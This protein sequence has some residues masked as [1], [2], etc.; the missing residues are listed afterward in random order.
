MRFL[1]ILTCLALLVGC[2]GGGADNDQVAPTPSSEDLGLLG[3]PNYRWIGLEATTN[4]LHTIYGTAQADVEG[5]LVFRGITNDGQAVTPREAATAYTLGP[6]ASL[7]VQ[8][9]TSRPAGRGGFGPDG[10]Y[11]IFAGVDPS[12]GV[13]FH[14]VMRHGTLINM[15]QIAD[16]FH[17][18]TVAKGQGLLGILAQAQFGPSTLQLRDRL[19]NAGFILQIPDQDTDVLLA[20]GDDLLIDSAGASLLGY[21]SEDG[22]VLLFGGGTQANTASQ[23]QIM[24]RHATS[25][26]LETLRGAYWIAGVFYGGFLTSLSGTVEF[27]GNGGGTFRYRALSTEGEVV[28]EEASISYQVTANGTFTLFVGT[29]QI[30]GAVT[31]D[32]RFAAIGGGANNGS[33]PQLHVLVRK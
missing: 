1:S 11:G 4:F 21:M 27:D 28:E 25:A 26:S 18:V 29:Q 12:H 14:V 32:G 15:D 17:A 31:G 30:R 6:A 7:D 5:E 3:A 23:L 22:N 16:P 24:V 9:A 8:S 2:G 20:T 13:Q 19:Q 33:F 10:A